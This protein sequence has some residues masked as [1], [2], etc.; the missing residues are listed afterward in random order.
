MSKYHLK[1]SKKIRKNMVPKIILTG[2]IIV[3]ASPELLLIFFNKDIATPI[4]KQA[5]G[6]FP[7]INYNKNVYPQA[8]TVLSGIG[9]PLNKNP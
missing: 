2:L 8:E 3:E 6:L 7:K 4:K 5:K 1:T 9:S